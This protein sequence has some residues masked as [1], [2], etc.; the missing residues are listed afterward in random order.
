MNICDIA[1]ATMTLARNAQEQTL[2]LSALRV[3][4][5]AGMPVYVTDA[6][7][8]DVFVDELRRMPNV[9]V[10]EPRGTGLWSQVRCSLQTATR[11]GRRF[12]LYTE[13]DKKEFFSSGMSRFIANAPDDRCLG[14]VIAGRSSQALSTFPK[15]QQYT[16]SVI[17]RCCAEV[18][19][20]PFDYSYGPFL[21]NSAAIDHLNGLPNDIGWG[22]RPHAFVIAHR[23]GLQIEQSVEASACP[24]DQRANDD[25]TYRMLQ[26][27]QSVQGV[28]LATKIELRKNETRIR[29]GD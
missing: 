27:A 2:L 13:P 11:S 19:G 18:I 4:A 28:V 8:G 10:C 3:L 25:R 9:N 12:I 22:W 20:K 24:P 15:F 21:I 1:I 29:Q 23:L 16:E 17:N 14:I 6:G 26:L 5:A 7:S